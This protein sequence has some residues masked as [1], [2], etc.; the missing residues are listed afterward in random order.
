MANKIKLDVELNASINKAQDLYK[1]IDAGKGFSGPTGK[2]AQA[3]FKGNWAVIEELLKQTDLTEEEFKQLNIAIKNVFGVL[4]TYAAK[5]ESLSDRAIELQKK[6]DKQL[7]VRNKAEEQRN[8]QKDTVANAKIDLINAMG[9]KEYHVMTKNGKLRGGGALTTETFAAKLNAGEKIGYKDEKGNIQ[10]VALS[11]EVAKQAELYTKANEKLANLQIKLDKANTALDNFTSQLEKQIE[12]DRKSNPDGGASI[13]TEVLNT[14]KDVRQGM[15]RTK[16][17]FIDAKNA[18]K[19]TYAIESNTKALERNQSTLGK[20]FKQFTLYNLAL[21]FTKKAIREAVQTVKELDKELTEQAMV[22]GMTREETYGLMKTYQK[23]A[24]ATGATTKEVA[25]VATEYIKQGKSIKEATLLTEAAVSAAK[26]ARVSVGDSVNYLTTAL[27]GFQLAATDAM[28]VSDKFAAV[29]AASATDYDELA[30]ALS[31][32]ASQANLA[33]MS[34]DYTTALLT[35][36]LETTREAPETMGTALKT[37]IARMRELGD[38]GE[39]LEGDTDINNVE[40]QL[41]YVDIALR[42]ANGELRSTEEVLDELGKKWDTL[43]KN[44]QAAV[45]KALAGTRQQSRLIAMMSDYERVT[46]LQQISQR[47]AGATAAQASVY[48]EGMEASLNK[49]TVAWEKIVTGLTNSEL[50]IKFFGFAGDS[51]EIIGDLFDHTALLIPLFSILAVSGINILGTKI[52]ENEIAKEEQALLL[53]KNIL[54]QESLVAEKKKL[55]N[56]EDANLASYKSLLIEAQEGVQRTKNLIIA[57]KQTLEEKKKEAAKL[58]QKKIDKTLT[59]EEKVRLG[60][61]GKEIKETKLSIKNEENKLVIQEKEAQQAQ[62]T[63]NEQKIKVDQLTKEASIE[64]KKLDLLNEQAGVTHGITTFSNNLFAT[65]SKLLPVYRAINAFKT[66]GLLLTKKEGQEEGKNIIKKKISASWEAIKSGFKQNWW[67]GLAALAV[68]GVIAGITAAINAHHKNTA[69]G[70]AEEVNKLSNEIYKLNEKANAIKQITSAYDELD[71]KIIKTKKDQEELNSLLEQA[72]DKLSTET[73]KS[74]KK[75]DK[76]GAVYYGKDVSEQDY[77]NS[78]STDREKKEFL[79]SLEAETNRQIK[80]RQQEQI[81]KVKKLND[82]K[83]VAFFNENTTDSSIKQAQSAFYAI[84]NSNLYDRIDAMTDITE[85]EAAAIESVTQAMI[86]NLS[87][88]GAY[89]YANN[90]EKVQAIIDKLKG[91]EQIQMKVNDRMENVSASEILN[92]DDFDLKDKVKAY[93]AA[94]KALEGIDEA[95][96]AFKTEY[97]QYQL[98]AEMNDDV[99]DFIDSMGWSIDQINTMGEGWKK[100]QKAGIAMTEAEYKALFTSSDGILATLQQTGGNVAATIDAVF[101]DYIDGLEGYADKYNQILDIF[102]E[103]MTVGMSNMGQNIEKVGNSIN[104]VYEKA[105]KWN[106]LKES[107]KMSFM[108]DNADLFEGESGQEMLAAFESGNYRRIEE[109]LKN[110]KGLQDQLDAQIKQI[111]NELQIEENRQGDERNEAYIKYLKEWRD[112]LTSSTDIFQ[113]DLEL[114][115]EQEQKQLDIYR[116]YLEKQ[117]D[118][119]EDALEKRKEAYEEYFDAIGQEQENADYE[120]E[121]NKLITNIS[122]LAGSTDFSSQKQMKELEQQLDDLEKERQKELR[123][124]AQEALIEALDKNVEE[125]NEKFDKLLENEGSLLNAMKSDLQTNPNLLS[126]ILYSA[127]GDGQMTALNATQY[128]KD[129]VSAF[130][131]AGADTSDIKE[132]MESIQ[133]NATFNLA[134]GQTVNIDGEDANM[135]W[136]AIQSILTKKGYG[137]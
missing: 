63:Y 42:D 100:L 35:K 106:E 110:N 123:E 21:K 89:D 40:K 119:L 77:Y 127:I 24:L 51:L 102:A 87:A 130:E 16:E 97:E 88:K 5:I 65:L 134:N 95:Y 22:T 20:A 84:A 14:E 60:I 1:Q 109:A 8:T 58:N 128:A 107:E 10:E 36:G 103:T 117:Q 18:E 105:S 43:N 90:P 71:N 4:N 108:Q 48:L 83:K 132:F 59:A 47:S 23:L 73:Y 28:K 135:L 115:I 9:G 49:I 101:G 44:Q 79:D 125:I 41:G 27:N 70:T 104:S 17:D 124:R 122:K 126:D 45:A 68:F 38:Y 86:A 55:V 67:I 113:A 93:E 56:Q 3:R 78:L 72:A 15:S 98:F 7:E 85:E 92:S 66:I 54:E 96:S 53:Q 31:K 69:E 37:I 133:N 82:R 52:R 25:G 32:V 75:A 13:V 34:I 131:S 11:S 33:G 2:E 120:E 121:R 129:L 62:E 80:I 137:N 64:Q 29:A 94:A 116:E 39:T 99:L 114:L 50:I 19:E 118:E 61:L 136:A 30:I 12:E 76:A 6:V 111:E 74:K 57:K 46:E 81:N 91:L 26:V 112:K